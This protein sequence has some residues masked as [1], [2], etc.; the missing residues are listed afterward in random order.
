MISPSLI[1]PSLISPAFFYRSK[2][3]L[4]HYTQAEL[5]S[6]GVQ[7]YTPFGLKK[8]NKKN[9]YELYVNDFTKMIKY[10][11]SGDFKCVW[12]TM[13][14]A[15]FI[16]TTTS[17]VA[18]TMTLALNQALTSSHHSVRVLD[19]WFSSIQVGGS[20]MVDSAHYDNLSNREDLA[21]LM[22]IMCESFEL[23]KEPLEL[24]PGRLLESRKDGGAF[25]R[26]IFDKCMTEGIIFSR[27]FCAPKILGITGRGTWKYTCQWRTKEFTCEGHNRNEIDVMESLHYAE[28]DGEGTKK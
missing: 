2:W 16:D 15:N 28:S 7:W 20:D 19:R 26:V 9:A 14:W 23:G 5:P 1:S 21:R 3:D 22:G 4:F 8:W 25:C 13:S 27:R 24:P 11:E 17:Q 6:K 12:V 10:C 18:A